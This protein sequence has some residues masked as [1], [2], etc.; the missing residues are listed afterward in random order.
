[1][2]SAVNTPDERRPCPVEG[3][4]GTFAAPL[5]RQHYDEPM[6]THEARCDGPD[7][8]TIERVADGPW[9]PAA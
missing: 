6:A 3:C 4:A 9:R 7:Q 8:H 5:D 1:M 2:T